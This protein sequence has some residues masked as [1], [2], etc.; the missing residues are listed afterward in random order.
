MLVGRVQTQKASDFA[1]A[2]DVDPEIHGDTFPAVW[3][4]T[5]GTAPAGPAANQDY[6]S[7]WDGATQEYVDTPCKARETK[8]PPEGLLSYVDRTTG[9]HSAGY[10]LTET[11]TGVGPDREIGGRRAIHL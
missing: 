5:Y 4:G 6:Q 3:C 10:T 8:G 11:G 7:S 9:R 1:R 2:I